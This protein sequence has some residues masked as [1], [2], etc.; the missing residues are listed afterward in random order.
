MDLSFYTQVFL[1][2]KIWTVYFLKCNDG[3][4][5]KGCTG[6]LLERLKQHNN[7]EVKY[8]STRLPVDL[9]NCHV[10]RDK[11]K[12]FQFEKYLKSGSG[13]AFTNRHLL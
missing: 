13:C 10:F 1:T 12:A 8:T 4:Y 5:Y 3:S 9:E 11:V 7:R 2:D 6:N